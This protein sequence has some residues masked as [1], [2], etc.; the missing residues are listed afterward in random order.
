MV[1]DLAREPKRARCNVSV[2]Y[3][4]SAWVFPDGQTSTTHTC[5]H[6]LDQAYRMGWP[7]HPVGLVKSVPTS[8][9]N[10]GQVN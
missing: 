8:Y 4:T 9:C 10:L 7:T 1:L 2:R 5:T 3:Y 6:R